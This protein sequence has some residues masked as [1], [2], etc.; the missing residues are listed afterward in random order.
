MYANFANALFFA[1]LKLN[2]IIFMSACRLQDNSKTHVAFATIR[3]T[4]LTISE[5]RL[6]A[7]LN[8]KGK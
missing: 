1:I 2:I 5:Q 6:L 4:Q 7:L 8:G 3:S